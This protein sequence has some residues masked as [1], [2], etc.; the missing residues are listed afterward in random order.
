MEWYQANAALIFAALFAFSEV[1]A[2]IPQIKANSI[3]QL[4]YSSIKYL[5]GRK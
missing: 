4:F 1:L 3:F 2:Q 5:S